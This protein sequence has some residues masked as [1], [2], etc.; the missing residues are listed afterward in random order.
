MLI[1]DPTVQPQLHLDTAGCN[2]DH[3][4]IQLLHNMR[5][6]NTEY[7][8]KPPAL[9]PSMEV[10]WDIHMEDYPKLWQNST[11]ITWKVGSPSEDAGIAKTFVSSCCRKF[12]T[13]RVTVDILDE[14]AIQYPASKVDNDEGKGDESMEDLADNDDDDSEENSDM[15]EDLQK[16][17]LEVAKKMDNS[18]FRSGV[19]DNPKIKVLTGLTGKAP[20]YILGVLTANYSFLSSHVVPWSERVASFDDFVNESA[21]QSGIGELMGGQALLRDCT[22]AAE[23]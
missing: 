21:G 2:A 5:Q 10:P 9:R 7:A 8:I 20:S 12:N 16:T 17:S 22:M 6:L 18:G 4:V 19:E 14:T 3:L 23:P 11:Y 15:D 13:W 1:V